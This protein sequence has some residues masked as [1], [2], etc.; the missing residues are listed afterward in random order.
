MKKTRT[1]KFDDCKPLD[2]SDLKF[3]HAILLFQEKWFLFI[4]HVLLKEPMGFNELSRRAKQVN[5]KTLSHRM[6]TLEKLGLVTR[7]VVKTLPPKTS[8]ELTQ[9]GKNLSEV[10]KALRKWSD[11]HGWE[12]T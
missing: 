5:P 8:Y 1:S 12:S 3:G 4:L 6:Q 2:K 11:K 10:F 7:T 9:A